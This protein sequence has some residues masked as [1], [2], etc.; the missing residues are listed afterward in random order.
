VCVCV[1]VCL[2]VH[3]CACVWLTYENGYLW[4]INRYHATL[5]K[6]DKVSRTH[7]FPVSRNDDMQ[8]KQKT[9]QVNMK[10]TDGQMTRPYGPSLRVNGSRFSCSRQNMMIGS[11]NTIVLPDPVNAMPIISRPDRLQNRNQSTDVLTNIVPFQQS[12]SMQLNLANLHLFCIYLQSIFLVRSN[13]F[14]SL[15]L[16]SHHGQT[17]CKREK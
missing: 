9:K 16:S 5:N 7:C 6:Y 3:A 4:Y 8:K 13:V 11:T 15:T 17:V 12:Y 14:T 1:C 2:C 10:L